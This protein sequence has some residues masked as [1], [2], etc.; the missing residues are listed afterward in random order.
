MANEQ[1]K[2]NAGGRLLRGWFAAALCAMLMEAGT[3]FAAVTAGSLESHSSV[4]STT[5]TRIKK[6][7][8]FRG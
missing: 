8:A 4:S 7:A 2:R 6:T 5:V 3:V 1:A